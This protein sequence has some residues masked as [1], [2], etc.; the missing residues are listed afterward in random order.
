MYDGLKTKQNKTMQSKW[1]KA[2]EDKLACN[3]KPAGRNT[4]WSKIHLT[5][6]KSFR[7]AEFLG[8]VYHPVL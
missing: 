3:H 4:E 7:I 1:A 2:G 6:W 8:F 5:G